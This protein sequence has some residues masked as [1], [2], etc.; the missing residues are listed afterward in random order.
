MNRLEKLYEVTLKLNEVV[1]K[2]VPPKDREE[3]I[4]KIS[5]LID[6]RSTI[7]EKVTPPYTDEEKQ[8][9]EKVVQVNEKIKEKMNTL[10]MELKADIKLV[11]KKKE[12]NRSYINPYGKLK[13]TD[14]MYLDSKQ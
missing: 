6:E 2:T 4:Q 9:G 12:S 5:Q 1:S 7:L 10:F 13:T 14:G 8:T 3:V 11:K